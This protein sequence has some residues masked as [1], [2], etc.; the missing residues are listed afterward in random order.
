MNRFVLV[1][2][3]EIGGDHL[4]S[5]MTADKEVP[6]PT[7]TR[8]TSRSAGAHAHAQGADTSREMRDILDRSAALLTQA[9]KTIYFINA[10][11]LFEVGPFSQSQQALTRVH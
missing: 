2:F 11:T 8:M 10:D 5:L 7:T 9:R 4:D 1:Q 3:I 6:P